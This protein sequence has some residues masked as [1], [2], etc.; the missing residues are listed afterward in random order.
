L[1][2]ASKHKLFNSGFAFSNSPVKVMSPLDVMPVAAS[3]A[4]VSFTKNAPPSPTD[5]VL[6]TTA[7]PALINPEIEA[8]A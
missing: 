4:P 3:I 7:D 1:L 2:S 8:S 6:F 5:N